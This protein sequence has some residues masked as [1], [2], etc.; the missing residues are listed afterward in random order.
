MSLGNSKPG[1]VAIGET[2]GW[3]HTERVVSLN[4]CTRSLFRS[5]T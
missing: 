1:Q 4:T 3:Y 2:F 5:A